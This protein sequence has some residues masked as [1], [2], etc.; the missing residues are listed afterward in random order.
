MTK[1][2]SAR[3]AIVLIM[4]SCVPWGHAVASDAV[5]QTL[6]TRGS[7]TIAMPGKAPIALKTKDHVFRD[8]TIATGEDGAAQIRFIDGTMLT[9][10]RDSAVKIDDFIIPRDSSPGLFV[11]DLAKGYFRFVTGLIAKKDPKTVRIG[12][13]FATIGVRGSAATVMVTEE[14]A[15]VA[16]TKCCIDVTSQ[17]KT[18][19]LDVPGFYSEVRPNQP[20]S[21]SVRLTDDLAAT[22]GAGLSSAPRRDDNPPPTEQEG[23]GEPQSPKA[24]PSPQQHGMKLPKHPPDVAESQRTAPPT[25]ASSNALQGAS[26][27]SPETTQPPPATALFVAPRQGQLAPEFTDLGSIRERLAIPAN[28]EREVLG[29]HHPG[30]P[31][32]T[33]AILASQPPYLTWGYWKARVN[34]GGQPIQASNGYMPF[35]S[36]VLTSMGALP[37]TGTATYQGG[38][39]LFTTDQVQGAAP[40]SLDGNFSMQFDFG[41]RTVTN[42]AASG[43]PQSGPTIDIVST[44]A[45]PFLSN[46]NATFQIPL[47]VTSG[48]NLIGTGT[49]QGGLFGPSGESAAGVIQVPNWGPQGYAVQGTFV[50]TQAD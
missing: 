24:A 7:V 49:A 8:G 26:I 36:G 22:M 35:V 18:V 38:F 39:G 13:P 21:A 44:A 30:S 12:T 46:E 11:I 2:K 17:G 25:E 10:G 37:Q 29:A 9:I 43:T 40:N 50:G 1:A 45:T 5:G 16:V 15:L 31:P 14:R 23:K 34:T 42:F 48:S 47:Q 33:Q 6:V 20:P 32:P 19:G 3:N 27:L 41:N 4:L 28:P